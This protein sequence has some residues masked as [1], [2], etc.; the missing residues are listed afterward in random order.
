ML[1]AFAVLT[2]TKPPVANDRRGSIPLKNSLVAR[3]ASAGLQQDKWICKLFEG[4]DQRFL[5]G[6][7]FGVAYAGA[8]IVSGNLDRYVMASRLRFC[9]IA[10]SKNSS[11]APV[12]PRSRNRSTRKMRFM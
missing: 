2:A 12:R 1:G 9:A 5:S 8:G 4:F 6:F 7:G 11:C 3:S 10:V